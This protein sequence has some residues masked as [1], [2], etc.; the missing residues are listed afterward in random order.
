VTNQRMRIKDVAQL[1]G[2][3]LSTI[4]F[5]LREGLLPAPIKTG[6]TM[7]YYGQEHLQR[8]AFI[9]QLQSEK[10]LPLYFIKKEIAK[11]FQDKKETG[12][13]VY[14][15]DH[16]K[17]EIIDSAIRVF[18]KKGYAATKIQDIVSDG[19][20]GRATFYLF[21]K[22][23]NEIFLECF[24]VLFAD[25]FKGIWEEIRTEPA[26]LA[27]LQK[28]AKIF[29]GSYNKWADTMNLLRGASLSKN[30][31]FQEKLHQVMKLIVRTVA[32]DI[33]KAMESGEIRPINSTLAGHMAM[34]MIEYCGY[35]YAQGRY[36]EK[37]LLKAAFDL[38]S[39]GLK[40]RTEPATILAPL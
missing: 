20:I 38:L 39:K 10:N 15:N 13:P 40:N 22:N 5:Y 17:K 2:V 18:R 30:P 23:K 6:K 12:S 25:L 36:D 32:R 27:R 31:E 21:F 37:V 34:G 26:G 8:L 33:E 1:S 19:G 35:L 28:R 3:P 29:L 14:S 7:A 9:R 11:E 16:K 4:R 24:D